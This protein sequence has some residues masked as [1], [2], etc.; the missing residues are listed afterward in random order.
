LFERLK[1]FVFCAIG[2]ICL[3]FIVGCGSA[4]LDS[5]SAVSTK[6]VVDE[7]KKADQTPADNTQTST[8][9]RSAVINGH[10]FF[11]EVAD[12]NAL[13]AKGLMNREVLALNN[14]MLFVF[15]DEEVVTFWMKDTLIP[16]D[17]LFLDHTLKIVDIQTMVP[18]I[19]TLEKDLIRYISKWPSKFALEI[20]AGLTHQYEIKTGMVVELRLD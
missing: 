2:L 9:E 19:G 20:N 7:H 18:Q 5:D 6:A 10:H 1:K 15:W 8:P 11:L 4:T 3:A 16:L 17:I 13:R 14:A 12:T